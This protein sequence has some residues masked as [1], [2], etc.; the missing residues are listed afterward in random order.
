MTYYAANGIEVNFKPVSMGQPRDAVDVVEQIINLEFEP[1]ELYSAQYNLDR[2]T[3]SEVLSLIGADEEEVGWLAILYPTLEFL[4]S[5]VNYTRRKIV[6]LLERGVIPETG[7][8]LLDLLNSINEIFRQSLLR[9]VGSRKSEKLEKPEYAVL[10]VSEGAR[11]NMK[12][13]FGKTPVV[14]RYRFF[15]DRRNLLEKPVKEVIWAGQAKGLPIERIADF[16]D[17]KV[18]ADLTTLEDNV[19]VTLK[20]FYDKLSEIQ[21]RLEAKVNLARSRGLL[22]KYGMKGVELSAAWVIIVLVTMAI[23]VTAVSTVGV[24][25]EI[26]DKSQEITYLKE[27]AALESKR[28]EIAQKLTPEQL[29][30]YKELFEMAARNVIPSEEDLLGFRKIFGGMADF[31]SFLFWFTLI[32]GGGYLLISEVVLPLLKKEDAK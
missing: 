30:T 11:I 28:L 12:E 15:D 13:R 7:R 29:K 22:T 10:I 18:I 24:V 27:Q 9:V 21:M 17:F 1:A 31:F 25:R 23:V 20:A 32:V 5:H 8:K 19:F 4:A 14:I 16:P 3:V 6:S 26:K 2:D